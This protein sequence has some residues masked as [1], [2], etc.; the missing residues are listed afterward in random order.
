MS[1][2]PHAKT[3]Q[4]SA[5]RT[6]ALT[7]CAT[8]CATP[9]NTGTISAPGAMPRPVFSADQPH[10]VCSHNTTDNSAPPKVT[11]NITAVTFDQANA[12]TRS[13]AGSTTGSACRVERSQK[14][15][16]PVAATT[17]AVTSYDDDQPQ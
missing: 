13:K 1:R 8:A 16:I 11:E 10:T 6:P 4:P 5:P 7:R 15:P 12:R 3:T 2:P 9:A 17:N 14:L